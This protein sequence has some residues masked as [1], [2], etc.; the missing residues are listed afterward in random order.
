MHPCSA[1]FMKYIPVISPNMAN[2]SLQKVG[3]F[4]NKVMMYVMSV[5]NP[6]KSFQKI[7]K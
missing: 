4:K 5:R 1:I 6:E 3:G 7:T 2:Y